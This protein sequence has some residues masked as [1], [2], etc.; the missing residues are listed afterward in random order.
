MR[1]PYDWLVETVEGFG[2]MLLV[3]VIVYLVFF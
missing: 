1:D 2:I 3:A